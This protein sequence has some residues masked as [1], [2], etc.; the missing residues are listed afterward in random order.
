MA[1]QIPFAEGTDAAGAVLVPDEY[2]GTLI[3]GIRRESAVAN[4]A[5]TERIG[6][7]QR[8]WSVYSGR[9]QVDF[10]DESGEKPVTG[11]EFSDLTLNV[12]KLAA[13]VIYTEELLADAQDDPRLLVTPDVV[14]AFADKI[15]AH[16]LGYAAGVAI[17]G[18]SSFDDALT[19]TTSST[20]LG[21]TGD[22]FA[23]S[24]SA[25]MASVEGEGYSPNA[26]IAASDVRAHL[27]DSR[28][29]VETT[30]PVYTAG[31]TQ[32]P[33]TLYGLPVNYSS[34]LDAFNAGAGKIA[35]VVGDFSHAILGVRQDIT[36]KTSDQATV[37]IGGTPRNLWQRNEIAVLWEM[38][39]GFA[40]HDVNGAFCKIANAS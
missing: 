3:D 24:V 4:L 28:Y 25:A 23:K 19:D 7:K 2:A 36:V 40:I 26:I 5:R 9:P 33:D 38:R 10:V 32:E 35:G 14:G 21:T 30:V 6:S 13:I 29:T 34:N 22:A 37:N 39:V 11:A 8:T 1:N 15:D 17:N 31:Y 27:R 18:G 16:A 12:K 20:E